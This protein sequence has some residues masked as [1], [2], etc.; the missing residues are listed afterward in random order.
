MDKEALCAQHFCKSP[1]DKV[2]DLEPAADGQ[3]PKAPFPTQGLPDKKW[4]KA[5]WTGPCLQLTP[6]SL[7]LQVSACTGYLLLDGQ[8]CVF[9]PFWTHVRT[10][11]GRNLR[12][13]TSTPGQKLSCQAFSISMVGR[14]LKETENNI[15]EVDGGWR[16]TEGADILKREKLFRHVGRRHSG[17]GEVKFR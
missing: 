17:Q 7:G 8:C 4:C 6:S 14:L 10:W 13:Q 1:D 9:L 5:T 12:P 11:H 15:C 3:S 16:N 2:S